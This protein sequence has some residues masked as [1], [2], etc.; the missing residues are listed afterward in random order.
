MSDSASLQRVGVVLFG[1]GAR[2]PLW[3][4]PMEQIATQMRDYGSS[5]ICLAFLEF[6]KPGLLE[7]CELLVEEHFVHQIVVIP[8]FLA[9]A[10][11][12]INDLPSL[13]QSVRER[14]PHITIDQKAPLGDRPEVIDVLVKSFLD[15][16]AAVARI[17]S[18]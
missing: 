6:L 9:G 1:H 10:G 14:F 18:N 3:A 17:N 15:D 5:P 8:V 2:N 11:H 4:K 12:L 13:L 7:A 16:V